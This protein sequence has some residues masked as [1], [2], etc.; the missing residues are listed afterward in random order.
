MKIIKTFI[1]SAALFTAT[2]GLA[3]AQDG[4]SGFQ[5]P[6]QCTSS[7]AMEN[8]SDAG[9][10]GSDDSSAG[11]ETPGMGMGMG[12]EMESMTEAQRANMER[13][14]ETMPAMHQGMMNE[15]PDIAFACGMIAHHRGAIDMAE[16]QLEFGEDETMQALAEK[17]IN[18]QKREI[19]EMTQ[20]L[21]D[22]AD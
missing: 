11:G 12:M 21:A 19:E 20:W 15:D 22:N 13:M 9:M 17:I 8:G 3:V 4:E 1:C 18:D 10:S 2:A 6:A 7:M 16:V 5:L 14:M